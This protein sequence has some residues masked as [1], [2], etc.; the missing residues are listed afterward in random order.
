ME[1]TH[2]SEPDDFRNNLQ[3]QDGSDDELEEALNEKRENNPRRKRKDRNE[4]YGCIQRQAIRQ[5]VRVRNGEDDMN[6]VAFYKKHKFKQ[7]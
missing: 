7:R 5:H 2:N 1:G 3:A 6:R 4:E